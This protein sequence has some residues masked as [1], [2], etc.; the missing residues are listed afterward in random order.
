METGGGYR[1]WHKYELNVSL[2]YDNCGDGC[3]GDDNSEEDDD[4]GDSYDAY[5]DNDDD[6][7]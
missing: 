2:Y 7:E 4:N 5:N 6:V 3:G 1:H